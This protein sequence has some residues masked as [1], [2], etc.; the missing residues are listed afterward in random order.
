MCWTSQSDRFWMTQHIYLRSVPPLFSKYIS[1][2][3][4]TQS[5]TQ[6]VTA[7]ALSRCAPSIKPLA[8][9]PCSSW[10]HYLIIKLLCATFYLVFYF[11]GADIARFHRQDCPGRGR[12]RQGVFL[13]RTDCRSCFINSG[14]GM[15]HCSLVCVVVFFC[16]HRYFFTGGT[17]LAFSLSRTHTHIT[18]QH[19]WL[20][21]M[22]QH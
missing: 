19:T 13:I 11:Y 6:E 16:L 14:R 18:P 7:S 10:L 4:H 2:E 3:C 17:T 22:T 9:C 12:R 5:R 21:S 20:E 15:H 8:V 1:P